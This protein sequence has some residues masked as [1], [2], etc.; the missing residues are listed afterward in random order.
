MRIFLIINKFAGRNKNPE[1]VAGFIVSELQNRSCEVD[2]SFTGYRGHATKL[3]GEAYSEKYDIIV[4]VGG[5]GTVNEVACGLSG[6]DAVMGII[7][8]GS[9]NGLA[10][11]L[12][13]SMKIRESTR[14]IVSGKPVKIDVCQINNQT[15]L[16]TAGIGFDAT[17]ADKMS[18]AKTRG[19]LQYVKLTVLESL[20]FQPFQ[21][22]MWM[23]GKNV[24]QKVF[25][26]TFANARQFGNN[27]FIA[28]QAIIHDGF[29]EVVVIRPFSKIWLPVFGIALFAGFIP[30][31]PFVKNYRVKQVELENAD[32]RFYHFDGEPAELKLPAKV[33]IATKKLTILAGK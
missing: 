31:L 7:P 27:A 21:I 26:V 32:T 17:I 29:I 8:T 5:D 13:I 30:K 33:T 9:G 20:S 4:A 12:G 19:F 15:F 28:P 3:A 18:R 10:R 24:E 2:F 14:N 16:C 25:I 11:E 1:K 23:D 22:K 6:T